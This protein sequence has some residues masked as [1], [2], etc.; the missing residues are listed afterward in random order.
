LL[1]KVAL[2]GKKDLAQRD[3]HVIG[4]LDIAVKRIAV[5]NVLVTKNQENAVLIVNQ[6]VVKVHPKN[7]ALVASHAVLIKFVIGLLVDAAGS[8]ANLGR[9]AM[10]KLKGVAKR[11][12]VDARKEANLR[13]SHPGRNL[14]LNARNAALI[15][16]AVALQEGVAGSHANPA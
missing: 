13:G 14:A 1:A 5:P 4:Q 6:K 12:L 8:H 7:H 3:G 16:F 11:N 10:K 15:K 2:G 9:L